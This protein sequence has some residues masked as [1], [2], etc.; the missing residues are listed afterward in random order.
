MTHPY[1]SQLVEL[2]ARIHCHAA[3]ARQQVPYPGPYYTTQ[4]D[5]A[6]TNLFNGLLLAMSSN[7]QH[8]LD[9]FNGVQGDFESLQ[10]VNTGEPIAHPFLKLNFRESHE[11]LADLWT[12]LHNLMLGHESLNEAAVEYSHAFMGVGLNGLYAVRP[13]DQGKEEDEK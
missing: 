10:S 1:H 5:R 4:V 2:R 6:V 13:K 8:S 11:A 12:D 3:I 7:G 9:A